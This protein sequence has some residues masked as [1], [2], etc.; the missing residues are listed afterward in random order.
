MEEKKKNEILNRAYEMEKLAL[1][2]NLKV[3]DEEIMKLKDEKNIL[4]IKLD[5]LKDEKNILEIK[6]DD[7]KDEN[8]KL[9]YELDKIIYSRNYKLT[10]K[11]TKLLKRR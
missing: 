11:I 2:D 5:D 10:K 6:L 1:M 9:R 8:K 3:R 4:E 7:L